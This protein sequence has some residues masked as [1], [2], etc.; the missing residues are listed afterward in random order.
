MVID[1]ALS[2]RVYIS[3]GPLDVKAADK[4]SVL[5]IVIHLLW[6]HK[7]AYVCFRRHFV[8]WRTGAASSDLPSKTHLDKSLT[9]SFNNPSECSFWFDGKRAFKFALKKIPQSSF[10]ANGSLRKE[11]ESVQLGVALCV[12]VIALP[13]TLMSDARATKLYLHYGCQVGGG[14]EQP[15]KPHALRCHQIL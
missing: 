4:C 6:L 10:E 3:P 1:P 9:A 15:R 8:Q 2:R 13:N 5:G 14:I 12:D 11:F 7:C